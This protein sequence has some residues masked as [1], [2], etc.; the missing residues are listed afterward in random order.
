MDGNRFDRISRS[1]IARLPR[2]EAVKALAGSG[3]VIVAA[4]L[5]LEEMD[6]RKKRC[7]KQGRSCGGKKKCCGNKL[8]CQNITKPGCDHVTGK[9]CCGLEGAVCN[10]DADNN[11]HCDCCDGFFCSGTT[12]LGHCQSTM[13]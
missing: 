5:G 6:A 10:N 8:K 4:R 1:L 3:L 9:R 12:G 13:T 11:S 2:R 7:R